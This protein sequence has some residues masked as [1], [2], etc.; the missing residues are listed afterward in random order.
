M[1]TID[2][3]IDPLSILFNARRQDGADKVVWLF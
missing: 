1:L 2:Q 3:L